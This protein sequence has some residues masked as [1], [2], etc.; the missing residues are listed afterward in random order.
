MTKKITKSQADAAWRT[1]QTYYTDAH[2]G[3]EP[4][5]GQTTKEKMQDA[6]CFETYNIFDALWDRHNPNYY[7]WHV[8]LLFAQYV[9]SPSF[10]KEERDEALDEFV[11]RMHKYGGAERVRDL[12]K[13]CEGR[14]EE[15]VS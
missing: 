3:I 7:M 13:L 12:Y 9:S 4:Q 6:A 8:G 15:E 10:S 5:S 2:G 14:V 11:H 1:L